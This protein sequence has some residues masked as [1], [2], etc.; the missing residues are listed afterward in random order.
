MARRVAILGAR[1]GRTHVG[2][3]RRAGCE[4]V[5]IVGSTP[6]QSRAV[7]EAEGIAGWDEGAIERADVVVVATPTPSHLELASRWSKKDVFCEKPFAGARA[8]EALADA[9]AAGRVWVNYAQ[10]FLRASEDAARRV[11][12]GKI[13]GEVRAEVAVRARLDEEP[14]SRAL[15]LEIA[16]HPLSF[17][18]HLLGRDRRTDVRMDALEGE[19]GIDVDV[20]LVGSDGRIDLSGRYRP[21]RGWDWGPLDAAEAGTSDVWYEANCRCVALYLDV[22]CGRVTPKEARARGMFDAARALEFERSVFR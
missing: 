13:G 18:H 22:I 12:R 16:V 17:V 15:L 1:W 14:P 21:G 9:V 2:T 3:F 4:V 6:E 8:R 20:A 7:A 5:A 19:R 11:Q 10:P